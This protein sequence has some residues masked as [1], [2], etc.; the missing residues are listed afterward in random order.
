MQVK[1][2]GITDVDTALVAAEAGA[3]AIGLVFAPSRRHVSVED[4]R[5]I[6]SAAPPFLT[7]VG[8]FVDEDPSRV[9]E[10]A[11]ACGL[12]LVQLHGQE[13]P[14][15]CAASTRPVIKAIRVADASSLAQLEGYHVAAFLLDAAV[16][17]VAG[18]SGRTFD[19]ALA[20]PAARAARVI[21]S[22]G[23]TPE[24][25][26]DALSRVRPFG[27]DVSSGVETSGRKDPEKI[28]TFIGRVRDWECAQ[29]G[30]QRW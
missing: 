9:N 5:A 12:D 1:I 2:C 18:G 23:L 6:A 22:G 4:A 30:S 28:R 15:V 11:T 21:L 8:V 29:R 20:A 16:P 25:V 10:L 27:V 19:W 26:Q 7:K 3:N 24:N 17:G 14:D 13:S